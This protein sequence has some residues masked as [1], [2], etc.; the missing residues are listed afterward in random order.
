[1]AGEVAGLGAEAEA[2]IVQVFLSLL[3]N[4]RAEKN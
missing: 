3:K 4:I 2:E 1:V